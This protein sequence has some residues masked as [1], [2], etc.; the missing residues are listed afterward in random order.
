[1]RRPWAPCSGPRRAA[2]ADPGTAGSCPPCA[3]PRSMT[4]PAAGS[5]LITDARLESFADAALHAVT[6]ASLVCREAQREAHAAGRSG[7]ITKG[8]DSPVTFADFA[9]QGVVAHALQ[10]RLGDVTLV[11]EEGSEYLRDPEH[12]SALARA[13]GAAARVWK[14]VRESTLLEAI[15]L[16]A[17]EPPADGEGFWTLDPIDGTKG[18]VRGEQYSVCLAYIL[19]GE[20]VIAALGCPNLPA[21]FDAPFQQRDRIGQVFVSLKGAG[22]RVAPATDSAPTPEPLRVM[23]RGPA[24][25]ARSCRSV[26][27]SHSDHD[28]ATRVLRAAGAGGEPLRLDSQCKYAVVARGQAE[29]YLRLPR[30]GGSYVER[31]WDHAPGAL[32]AREAGCVVTDVLGK[33]LDFSKGRGLDANRGVLCCRESFHEPILRAIR[34]HLESR[35]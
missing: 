35:S 3:Y 14:D 24:E 1:M 22:V 13:T 20:P 34:E 26:D 30:R 4:H 25:P 10:E 15:D 27:A 7:A 19:R 9:S 12:A 11:G 32:I 23:A 6:L 17:A 18:F 5:R 31:I 33:P 28:A 8:D 2:P 21:S 16:G 29:V